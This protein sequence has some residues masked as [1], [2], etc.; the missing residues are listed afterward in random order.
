MITLGLLKRA[1][2]LWYIAALSQGHIEVAPQEVDVTLKL[3]AN[4]FATGYIIVVTLCTVL[5]Q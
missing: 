1:A 2:A 5:C 3:P 4:I